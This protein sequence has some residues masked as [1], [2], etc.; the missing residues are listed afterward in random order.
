MK[1]LLF[2]SPEKD[3]ARLEKCIEGLTRNPDF[4]SVVSVDELTGHLCQYIN[5]YA[6]MILLITSQEELYKI[7][8]I[9][10]HL[11]GVKTIIILPDRKP[12]TIS[13]ALKLHPRYMTYIDSAF[14]DVSLVLNHMLGKLQ[15][16]KQIQAQEA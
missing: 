1:L 16:I 10:K 9:D 11:N 8:S 3:R 2:A 7:L 6:I 4:D 5:V 12:T 13:S 15:P 14:N